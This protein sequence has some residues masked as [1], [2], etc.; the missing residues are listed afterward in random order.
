M[1]GQCDLCGES[2]KIIIGT[3]FT[4]CFCKNCLL[5]VISECQDAIIEIEEEEEKGDI[6]C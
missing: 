4:D 6:L 1:R 5:L 3:S 2:N